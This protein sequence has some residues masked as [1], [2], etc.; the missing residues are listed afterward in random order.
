MV[1][2]LIGLGLGDVRDITVKGLEI[3][4]KCNKVYLEVYTSIL[5][6]GLCKFELE[7]FYERTI[8]E[9]DRNFVEEDSGNLI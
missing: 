2:Y 3:I 5:C 6:Y 8:I 1:F 4:R 9:A 7:K